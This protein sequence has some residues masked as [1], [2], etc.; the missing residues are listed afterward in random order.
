[1]DSFSNRGL[2]RLAAILGTA[3]ALGLSA[4]GESSKTV[5]GPDGNDDTKL[6][7]GDGSSAPDGADGLEGSDGPAGGFDPNVTSDPG[8]ADSAVVN[9]AD[10]IERLEA[11]GIAV[12]LTGELVEQPFFTPDAQILKIGAE[13]LEV[14]EYDTV[15][16]L[17]TEA[18]GVSRRRTRHLLLSSSRHPKRQHLLRP[19][20]SRTVGYHAGIR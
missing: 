3:F 16:A 1:M 19:F 5:A 20:L 10:L 2:F 12:E 9:T 8:F 14:F 7:A 6:T 13:S 15:E 18:R 17:K 11:S 4:C